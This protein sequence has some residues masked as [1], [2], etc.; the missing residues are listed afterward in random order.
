M[1][2]I[3]CKKI[4]IAILWLLLLT[5][6]GSS[7]P[8]LPDS[9]S[10]NL[11][12]FKGVWHSL[13]YGYLLK[14]NAQGMTMF[15]V[16]DNLCI[17]KSIS[18]HE[19]AAEL[20]HFKKL[21][22]T[23]MEVSPIKGARRYTF[24]RVFNDMVDKCNKVLDESPTQTFETF[25]N[26]MKDHYA[27]FDLYHVNWD[28]VVQQHRTLINQD[29]NDVTL[30]KTLSSMLV[31]INDAHLNLQAELKG[32]TKIYRNGNSRYLRPALD[33]AFQYQTKFDS[34]KKFRSNWYQI[35]KSNIKTQ[36]LSQQDNNDFDE[37]IIW[38]SIGNIGYIN[39]L[40]MI[41]FSETGATKDEVEQAKLA[42]DHVMSQ[43]KNSSAIIVD[44]TA[45]GGGEDEVSRMFASYFTEQPAL[46]YKKQI[47]GS[48]LPQQSFYV[49]PAKKHQFLGPTFL[50]TSDHSVS[51]AEI[52]TLAM[53]SIKNVTHV[54]ETTRGALS[55]IL[56]K[57]LPNGWRL[58]LSNEIYFDATGKSWESKGIPPQKQIDI[59]R[60]KNINTSHLQ[61]MKL[62]TD[63]VNSYLQESLH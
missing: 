34:A 26:L 30:Y 36:L 20:T 40:R 6:C 23:T 18:S 27:F 47:Y 24:K 55:D 25:A 49:K 10:F 11:R 12:D 62:I 56:D 22:E 42:M 50:V 7:A 35:Y 51:A 8:K 54:G 44:V 28:E 58:G 19:I 38:G 39:I 3:L 60:G 57:D 15:D 46:A 1:N 48:D 4:N 2:N 14:I 59:F 53:R 17:K 32:T 21:N 33:K 43:L 31:D 37:L 45:N 29:T 41:G 61:S 13:E 16:I 9:D 52:F 63:F 5:G